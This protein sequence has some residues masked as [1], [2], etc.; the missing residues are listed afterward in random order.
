MRIFKKDKDSESFEI[1]VSALCVEQNEEG[2]FNK[3]CV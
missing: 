3:I 1:G 2:G